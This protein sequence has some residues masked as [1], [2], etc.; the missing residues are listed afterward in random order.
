MSASLS[1]VI[2]TL[3]H[4]DYLSDCLA[5]L[6]EQTFRDFDVLMKPRSPCD[7][8]GYPDWLMRYG[9]I[10]RRLRRR[11]RNLTILRRRR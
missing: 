11:A 10:V 6:R 7:R 5:S 3:N 4:W 8:R 2:P 1:I 9:P